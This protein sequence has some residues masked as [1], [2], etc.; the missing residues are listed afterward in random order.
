MSG[1]VARLRR[2]SLPITNVNLTFGASLS[3]SS[4]FNKT[5]IHSSNASLTTLLLPTNVGSSNNTTPTFPRPGPSS[6]IPSSSLAR[7]TIS[8]AIL[9]IISSLSSTLLASAPGLSTFL[10]ERARMWA[11]KGG[12]EGGEGCEARARWARVGG[13]KDESRS[14]M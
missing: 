9:R 1:V 6:P 12:R 13:L 10:T 14:E 11:W 5:R 2:S 8:S 4:F 7:L 3:L